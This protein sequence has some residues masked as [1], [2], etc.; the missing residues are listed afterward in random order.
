M[1]S[2]VRRAAFGVVAAA[3]VAVLAACGPVQMGAAAVVG[4]QRIAASSISGPA[5]EVERIA[6]ASSEQGSV[7][8]GIVLTRVIDLLITEQARREGIDWSQGDI[9]KAIGK[10]TQDEGL[11]PGQVYSVPLVSGVQVQLP[12]SEARRFGRALYLEQALTK[13]YGSADP[14]KGQRELAKRLSALAREIGVHVNP[15]YGEFDYA[16][17]SLQLNYGGLWVPAKRPAP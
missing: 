13:R 3:A 11:R 12:T 1:R 17:V 14:E 5:A 8:G 10:A 9:D 6:P 7:P 2:R 16:K 15:R 4:D